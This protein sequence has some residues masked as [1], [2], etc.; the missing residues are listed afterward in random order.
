M[1]NEP[2][3]TQES[4]AARNEWLDASWARKIAAAVDVTP[5]GVRCGDAAKL[6]AALP[7]LVERADLAKLAE[8]S[9][10]IRDERATL[11]TRVAEL[12]AEQAE[13]QRLC[14]V[15]GATT[16]DAVRATLMKLADTLTRH[17]QT[18]MQC[19]ALEKRLASAPVP[20][21]A[22][23]PTDATLGEVWSCIRSS[24]AQIQSG[25]VADSLRRLLLPNARIE[26]L[27]AA[28]RTYPRDHIVPQALVDM[29][30][31]LGVP[32]PAQPGAASLKE[33]VEGLTDKHFDE[34]DRA[35][36]W[37]PGGTLWHWM[38]PFLLKLF[39][40]APPPSSAPLAASVDEYHR[41]LI[42]ARPAA[43]PRN[44][45][46]SDIVLESSEGELR[47][48]M[49]DAAF[50]DLASRGRA[51]ANRALAGTRPYDRERVARAASAWRVGEPIP[52]DVKNPPPAAPVE[53]S[54]AQPDYWTRTWI[55][56]AWRDFVEGAARDKA[57][58]SAATFVAEAKRIGS[59]DACLAARSAQG[60]SGQ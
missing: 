54:E 39:E 28:V 35:A 16:V 56:L 38:K 44:D 14:H 26:K 18:L 43:A 10:V 3:T 20:C 45:A 46:L 40:I 55:E 4:A 47:E 48:A 12:E 27:W 52:D 53:A 29:R 50:E 34:C 2:K 58:E 11:R 8:E 9:R 7:D 1:S 17:A 51:A 6:R 30:A 31:A 59:V 19:D 41:S 13:I 15:D 33:W 22:F 21:A 60:G 25:V 23:E 32:S 36:T 24:G 5:E 37:E 49:G 57:F 42:E